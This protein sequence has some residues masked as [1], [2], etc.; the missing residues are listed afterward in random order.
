MHF[1][2]FNGMFYFNVNDVMD[3]LFLYNVPDIHVVLHVDL[4]VVL[5]EEKNATQ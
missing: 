5:V 2:L 1:D 3:L 4:H